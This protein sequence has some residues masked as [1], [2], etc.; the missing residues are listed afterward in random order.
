MKIEELKAHFT[1]AYRFEMKTGMAANS[2]RNWVKWGFIPMT[3]QCHRNKSPF[4]P[5]AKAIGLNGDLFL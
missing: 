5:I 1:N 3:S 2:F 4:N